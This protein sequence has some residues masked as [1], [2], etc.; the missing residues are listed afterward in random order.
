VQTRTR[1]ALA[2]LG[3]A[4]A[5]G[6]GL[7]AIT[8]DR[9]ALD[10]GPHALDAIP[11]GALLVAT[12]DL[13]A[14]RASPVGAPFLREGREI[15]G[16]GKVRD[17]C[18]FD[19]MDTLSE[20]AV[21]IPASGDAGEFGLVAAGAVDQEALLKCASKVIEARGG[22]PVVTSIG[23]F[24]SVHDA[25][26]ATTG[27]EIAVRKGG[28]LLLGAGSYLR[29]MID[30]AEGRVPTI[31]SSVAHSFLGR[32]VQGASVRVTVVLSP[33][34]RKA[35]AEEL[36]LGGAAGS[37]AGE[38]VAG[39]LG[40]R[41]GPMVGLHALLS[42]QSAGACAKL[43]SNLREARD[44]RARDFATRM[45]GFGAVLEKIGVEAEGELLHARVEVPAD[46]AATLAERLLTLRGMR[47]PMPKGSASVEPGR[48]AD[49]GAP[50][51][52]EVIGAR[53]DAGAPAASG[54]ASA[55]P[56]AGAPAK[57]AGRDAGT[58]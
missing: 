26:L 31:R 42:C 9:K 45:V 46:Q 47:H 53:R 23:G 28:P 54:S 15:P 4:A 8:R 3:V 39:A 56:D 36:V 20:V 21:A 16:L 34:Q 13:A 7:F 22:R 55:P 17:V 5:L 10:L 41:L 52:D 32:E 50:S 2:L 38:V 6:A 35:L 11:S 40:I 57:E 25:T 49:A 29:A 33:E 30:A 44:A 24:R 48:P 43:A 58:R 37:P 19:P 14:L 12:A 51:L 18:G 27:G 1:N